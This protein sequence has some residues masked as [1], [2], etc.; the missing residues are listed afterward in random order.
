MDEIA[1]R[2]TASGRKATLR[3]NHDAPCIHVEI[4]GK[5]GHFG[6]RVSPDAMSVQVVEG[7]TPLRIGEIAIKLIR[8]IR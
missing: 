3:Y 8:R 1:V 4:D 5:S 7:K 2:N 6:F